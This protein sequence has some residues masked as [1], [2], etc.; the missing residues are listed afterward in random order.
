MIRIAI[1]DDYQQRALGAADWASLGDDVDIVSFDHHLGDEDAV[2]AALADFDVVVVMRERTP[3]PASLLARLRRLRLLVST[4][5]RNL[6]IDMAAARAHGVDV[7]GTPMTSYA[8]FEHTWALIMT[9]AKN[10]HLEDRCMHE[11]GWQRWTGVGLNGRT[12]GVIGLG[13]LGSQVAKI[14]AAFG[15]QLL[16]WSHNLTEARAAEC[17][18]RRVE[19]DTLLAEADVVTIHQVL[20]ERTRGLLGT[21][22]LALMKPTAFLVNTSRGPIVD[23]A[24]LVETLRERRI[25]GAAIDVYDTE[26]LPA[27]HPLRGL[28]NALLTGHTGYVIEEMFATAYGGAVE[29]I[30]GWRDGE[31]VRPMNP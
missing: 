6:S 2:A 24:A 27:D 16:A 28:D 19:L 9:L 7:C 1:L 20:S 5:L 15:M 18:A 26:P 13:K 8:A 21:R 31:L 29:D 22:E 3:F 10:I 11:G 23:E 17:G 25:A 14:G 12:L 30:R 4:G